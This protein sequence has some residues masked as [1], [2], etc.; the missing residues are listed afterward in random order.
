MTWLRERFVARVLCRR[1]C[2]W[3]WHFGSSQQDCPSWWWSYQLSRST[4]PTDDVP[5]QR[6]LGKAPD[7]PGSTR[8][9]HPCGGRYL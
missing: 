5:T 6:Q 8:A 2:R 3:A 1:A 4:I 9:G 7:R